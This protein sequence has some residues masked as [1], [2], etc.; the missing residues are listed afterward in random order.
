MDLAKSRKRPMQGLFCT[1][2]AQLTELADMA[3]VLITHD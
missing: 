2:F 3:S 1:L